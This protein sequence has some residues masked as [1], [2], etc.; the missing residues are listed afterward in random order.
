MEPVQQM[1]EAYFYDD[2]TEREHPFA[3]CLLYLAEDPLA[4][5]LMMPLVLV[6]GRRSYGVQEW[7]FSRDLLIESALHGKDAGEG[8]DFFVQPTNSGVRRV[9]LVHLSSDGGQHAHILLP[10]AQTRMFVK[11][12]LALVPQGRENYNTQVDDMLRKLFA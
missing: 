5:S 6:P 2:D 10:L 3:A 9:L 11:R 1:I 4:V 12:T 8:G 7:L